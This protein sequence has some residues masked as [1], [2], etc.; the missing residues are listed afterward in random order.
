MDLRNRLL[1]GVTAFAVPGHMGL[2][3]GRLRGWPRLPFFA[4]V[5]VGVR[6]A[7]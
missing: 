4:A 6:F 2:L 3:Y 5:P 7:G 1:L